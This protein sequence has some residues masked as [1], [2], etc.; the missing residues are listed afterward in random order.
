MG[1]KYSILARDYK[2]DIWEVA[3][4]TNNLFKAIKVYIKALRKYELIEFTV[5]K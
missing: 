1:G 3:L 2:D 5:R 4:Y